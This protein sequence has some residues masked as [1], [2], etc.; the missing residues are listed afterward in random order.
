MLFQL[1]LITIDSPGPFNATDSSE[2]F[3]GDHAVKAVVGARQPREFVGPADGK[4][5][6]SGTLFPDLFA[7][8]GHATGLNEVE[9]LRAMAEGGAPQIL[10]R[11]DGSNLGWWIIEKVS[12]KASKLSAGGVGRVIAYDIALVKSAASASPADALNLLVS[13]FV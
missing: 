1:G 5:T 11:G 4:M 2:E 12:Q 13:L 10:V 9:T 7:R 3:G 8:Y 6:L